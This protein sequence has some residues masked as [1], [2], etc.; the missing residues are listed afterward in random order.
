MAMLDHLQHSLFSYPRF[1]TGNDRLAKTPDAGLVE[2][3][4]ERHP[5]FEVTQEGRLK[6]P[7]SFAMGG[8]KAHGRAQNR[9]Q[10]HIVPLLRVEAAAWRLR[11]RVVVKPEAC[12]YL[13]DEMRL[14][15]SNGSEKESSGEA[16]GTHC[17]ARR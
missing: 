12:G 5:G 16:R 14:R 6:V 7:G 9:P 8:Q 1:I 13:K 15:E 11:L 4:G 3:P 17:E 2:N 10:S